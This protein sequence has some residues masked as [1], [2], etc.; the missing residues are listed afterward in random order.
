MNQCNLLIITTYI[1]ELSCVCGKQ[2]S[3]IT[4]RWWFSEAGLLIAI[5]CTHYAISGCS[6]HSILKL[7]LQQPQ[8]AL[9]HYNT[10]HKASNIH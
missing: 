5:V 10:L 1:S 6:I 7:Q 3:K 2:V 8:K 4:S 9:T